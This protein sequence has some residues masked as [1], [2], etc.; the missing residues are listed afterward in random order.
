MFSCT[1][2]S[3]IRP[4]VSQNGVC[5]RSFSSSLINLKPK[6]TSDPKKKLKREQ[7]V[8]ALNKQDPESHPLYMTIPN[9]MR[10]LRAAEVGQPAKKTTVSI[11]MTVLPDKGSTP[12]SGSVYLPKPIKDN[13][14]MVFSL[15][16]EI[17]EKAK[18]MGATYA[19]GLDLIEEIQNG[20]VKLDQLTHAFATPDVVKDLKPIARQIGPKGLM[21]T[22]KRGTVSEDIETLMRQSV[23][24]L[25]FKQKEQH[26]SIPIGRCD[27]SDEEIISNL[28]AASEAIYASQPPGTRKPNIIGRTFMSSTLGPSVIINFKS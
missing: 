1:R 26:L 4:I 14:V 2:S 11:L 28:K 13:H 21:P 27:F 7:K 22:P 19:G 18:E 16:P 3:I 15:Q 6:A 25:P 20:N 23:G 8:K 24:A 12:L 10:Y 5:I 17:V 9:A